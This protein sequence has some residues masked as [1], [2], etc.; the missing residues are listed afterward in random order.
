MNRE[1]I[2]DDDN[3]LF[4]MRHDLGDFQADANA[5]YC[6]GRV[7]GRRGFQEQMLLLGL[8]KGTR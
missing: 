7:I 4:L 2:I 5:R 1:I 3:G 8:L 6:K